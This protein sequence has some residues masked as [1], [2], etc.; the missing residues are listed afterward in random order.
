MCELWS[1]WN[2]T[3]VT[4]KYFG[5]TRK[6]FHKIQHTRKK[7][8]PNSRNGETMGNRIFSGKIHIFLLK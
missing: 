3:I 2:I 4:I 5:K 1:F 7:G 8:I 6:Q